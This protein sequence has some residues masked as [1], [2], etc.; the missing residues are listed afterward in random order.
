MWTKPHASLQSV[1][2]CS[3][4]RVGRR[5]R[6]GVLNAQ[7]SRRMRSGVL[8]ALVL[9]AQYP[10]SLRSSPRLIVV[11]PRAHTDITAEATV[12]W[13]SLLAIWRHLIRAGLYRVRPSYNKQICR[14]TSR[15]VDQHDYLTIQA[16]WCC[17]SPLRACCNAAFI[18][19]TPQWSAHGSV[20]SVRLMLLTPSP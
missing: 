12:T 17:G 10:D 8:N 3:S 14:M 5:M 16:A 4:L 20:H 6:S 9:T 18:P 2:C 15:R 1:E 19:G 13:C 11:V 7:V